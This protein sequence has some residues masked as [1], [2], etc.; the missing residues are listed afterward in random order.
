MH[1]YSYPYLGG[2]TA[3]NEQKPS[4]GIKISVC[5]A[6]KQVC[7]K[8]HIWGRV[9]KKN[10]LHWRVTE[11]SRTLPRSGLLASKL[12]NWWRRALVRVVKK[13][14]MVPLVELHDH[15]WRNLQKDK[16][17][18]NT[19]PIWDL[20]WCRQ[21]QSSPTFTFD[22]FITFKSFGK[23][24]SKAIYSASRIYIFCQY[25][26]SLEIEPT[27][28]C[29]AK[30]MLYH[31]ATGTYSVSQLSMFN[32]PQWRQKKTHLEFTKKHLKDP[33]TLINNI[34]WSDEPQFQASCLKEPSSAH[35]LQSTIPK[36]KWAGSF[37]LWGWFSAAVTEGP[38]R[39]EEMLNAPKYWD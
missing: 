28:F 29:A 32:S 2:P 5:R 12:S 9:Q 16:H 19:P 4:P 3:D 24:L 23:L 20:W 17:H 7:V 6:Q 26:R 11:T 1:K 38:F 30:A 13:K 25:V 37:M 35:L 10:L 39:V 18:C 15:M 21:T 31:W 27:T 8:P 22:H 34:F 33:Q 36:V 14:L